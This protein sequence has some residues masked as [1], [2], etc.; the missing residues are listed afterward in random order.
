MSG[1][2]KCGTSTMVRERHK[3]QE[4]AVKGVHVHG[5]PLAMA[6]LGQQGLSF[7]H[8]C[9]PGMWC[10]AGSKAGAAVLP[11]VGRAPLSGP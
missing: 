2:P 6:L 5:W 9:S 3:P 7:C 10:N 8:G 1:T 11:W 4:V